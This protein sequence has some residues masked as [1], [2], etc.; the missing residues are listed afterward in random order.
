MVVACLL[1]MSIPVVALSV[2]TPVLYSKSPTGAALKTIATAF[3]KFHHK[4]TE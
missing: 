3:F 4:E 1:G 2:H